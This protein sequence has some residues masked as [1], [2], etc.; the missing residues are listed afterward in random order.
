[1][2]RILMFNL[3]WKEIMYLD[4][5]KKKKIIGAIDV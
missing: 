3:C 1:M 4:S 2:N 5:Y